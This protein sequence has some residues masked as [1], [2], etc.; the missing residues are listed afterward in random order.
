[1]FIFTVKADAVEFPIHTSDD[2]WLAYVISGSGTL[3]AG[4]SNDNKTEGIS[5]QA[6]DFI[7]FDANTPHGWK[8]ANQE[9]KILFTKR[10]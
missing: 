9:S 10:S 6:S 3:Y 7:S 1:M 8:N 5:Y 2:K 4:D